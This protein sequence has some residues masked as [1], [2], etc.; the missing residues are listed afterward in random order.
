MDILKPTPAELLE[1]LNRSGYLLESEISKILSDRGYFNQTNPVI[2][3]RLTGK[4]REI[5]LVS[6]YYDSERNYENMSVCKINYV[7]EIKNNSAPVVLLTRYDYSPIVPTWEGI[8]EIFTIPEDVKYESSLNEV[9]EDLIHSRKYSIFSQY[10]SFQY[11][12]DQS[13]RELMA[14]S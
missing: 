14:L 10:C 12:K 3:D 13:K 1:S 6:E 2:K 5:D 11:K 9:Y 8:R 4:S 7:F